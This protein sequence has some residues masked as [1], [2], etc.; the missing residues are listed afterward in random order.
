[1]LTLVEAI[2]T[3]RLTEFIA[4]QETNGVEKVSKNQ[5]DAMIK[6]AVKAPPPQDQTSG[7]RV[8]GGSNGK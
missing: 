1:M 3:G 6:Q 4:E 2:R 7:S 8:R 5:F